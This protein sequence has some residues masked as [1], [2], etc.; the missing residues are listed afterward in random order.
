LPCG[1]PASR[2]LLTPARFAPKLLQPRPSSASRGGA[3]RCPHTTASPTPRPG[4]ARWGPRGLRRDGRSHPPGGLNTP[5]PQDCWTNPYGQ[6]PALA[7]RSKQVPGAREGGGEIRP[8][9]GRSHGAGA[10]GHR[11]GRLA[12]GYRWRGY[13]RTARGPTEGRPR[14]V[15]RGGGSEG[16]ARR[17][18]RATAPGPRGK[19]KASRSEERGC[20]LHACWAK[21]NGG[22]RGKAPGRAGGP[23]F[24]GQGPPLAGEAQ[25]RWLSKRIV[26]VG[27][28]REAAAGPG[29]GDECRAPSPQRAQA[30]P[31]PDCHCARL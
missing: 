5:H 18:A 20:A 13:I 15:A 26:C 27:G 22:R 11:A 23:P 19:T 29:G 3:P 21:G 17:P 12:V 9:G 24:A 28:T 6:L 10:C 8:A 30:V 7:R 4:S 2:R 1:C 16:W 31:R 25:T 14:S